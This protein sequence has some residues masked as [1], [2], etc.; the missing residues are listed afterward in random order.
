MS[1][2][3]FTGPEAALAKVK[4]ITAPTLK[5]G[6]IYREH[7]TSVTPK[8]SVETVS[9]YLVYLF[10]CCQEVIFTCTLCT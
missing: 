7:L 1:R 4:V 2:I 5:P 10:I 3:V 8:E 6:A 9:F